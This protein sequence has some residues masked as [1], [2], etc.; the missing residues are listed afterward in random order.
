MGRN[1]WTRHKHRGWV[2]EQAKERHP[3]V[4]Y[5]GQVMQMLLLLL[6]NSVSC[7][8]N[9]LHGMSR[10]QAKVQRSWDYFLNKDVAQTAWNCVCL[11]LAEW[12]WMITGWEWNL[13]CCALAVQIHLSPDSR[14]E[15]QVVCF[16]FYCQPQAFR[17]LE[18]IWHRVFFII[19][20]DSGFGCPLFSG[21][22]T[23]LFQ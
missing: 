17:N 13:Y 19:T 12:W 21:L 16:F 14:N 15:R 8:V 2:K 20:M 9:V 1:K 22:T 6:I 10:H 4:D 11:C 23:L 3:Q 5:T 7:Y 18:T